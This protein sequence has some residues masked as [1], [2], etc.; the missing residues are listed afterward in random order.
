MNKNISNL[1]LEILDNKRKEV[2]DKILPYTFD[3]VL[4]GGTA[5]ALQLS[6]RK[7]FDFDFFSSSQIPKNLLE[8]ISQN[9]EI[10][11]I[12]VDMPDELT[13]F[14]RDN[15][16]I[17]FLFYPFKHFFEIIR[18]EKGLSI[19]P[20]QEIALQ[21][22]YTIGRRGEYRDYFDLYYVLKD[23]HINLKDIIAYS[24]EAYGKVFDE[25][26]FLEQLIYFGDLTNFEIIPVN[27]NSSF[28]KPGDIKRFLEGLVKDY[29]NAL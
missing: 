16:K 11:N 23:G 27:N 2:L 14:T 13:F 7:S 17:T 8:K 6:H 10:Q 1:H 24:K 18:I 15:I 26:I 19:F 21:K 3:F 22:A 12:A 20:V 28:P 29:I 25:K 4:S 5:L 9:L